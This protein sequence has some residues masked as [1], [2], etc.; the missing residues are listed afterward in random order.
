MREFYAFVRIFINVTKLHVLSASVFK[1]SYTFLGIPL[2]KSLTRYTDFR[3]NELYI[4]FRI[5][6]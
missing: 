2:R 5:F 1:K 6:S 4:L 3:T